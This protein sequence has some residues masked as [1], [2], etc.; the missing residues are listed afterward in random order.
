[1]D[2]LDC[3]VVGAGIIGLAVARSLARSGREVLVLETESQVGMHASSRNSEVIHAGI[4][5]PE[6]SLK[7]HLCVQ[8]KE[9]L[10]RYCEAHHVAH[11]RIG[12]L[13]VAADRDD[14]DKLQ[15]I[16]RQ[17]RLNGV[18]DLQFLDAS[19]VGDLEPALVSHGALLSPSTGIIDTHELV[20]ALEG[21][22]EATGGTV[23]LNNEVTNLIAAGGG[24]TFEAGGETFA[25]KTLVNSAGLWAAD[26]V[27]NIGLAASGTPTSY[28]AKGHYFAYP[29]KSPF[30]HLVYP[31]PVDGGLGIHA[32]N[33][34]GGA[35][36]FGP[37]VTWVDGID[38]RF[39]EG[40]REDFA[41]AIRRYFPGLD[42][43]T[44]V[45]VDWSSAW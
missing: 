22:I 18:D 10:Y 41:P 28:L 4:Y 17:A 35:A 6:D 38:Y 24:L 32:T 42:A 9:M 12:K 1:M 36:R 44:P 45:L 2:R 33:D 40:R 31:V 39:D 5:Y 14:V 30:R 8:G 29:G 7:A 20:T 43:D 37:D 25:C 15:A 3:V 34:M 21:E 19:E 16:E 23:L 26:L 11:Q 27:A 13:I